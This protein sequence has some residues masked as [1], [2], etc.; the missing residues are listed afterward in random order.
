MSKN[1]VTFEL[2]GRVD[3]HDLENGIKAFRR[4]ISALTPRSA[5]V[6]WVVEDLRPGSMAATLRGEADDPS[7]VEKVIEDYERIG[8]ALSRREELTRY[9]K[10]IRSAANAIITL[11]DKAEYV[12]FETSVDDYMIYGN[13]LAAI[14]SARSVSV[15]AVTG[16]VQTL[17]N[18]G[19]LRF[20]LYDTVHD[21]AVACYLIPGQ[22]ALMREAWG[23]TA[24]VTGRV[25]RETSTGR[26][27]AIRK[28]MSVDI[29]EEAPHLSYRRA[30]GTVPWQQG[31]DKP[32]EIIRRLRDA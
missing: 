6:A 22:E 5:N 23:R 21:K 28:V 7:V 20:N 25:S 30:R 18:R 17:I 14:E 11:T 13:G 19:G 29:L 3:I 10:R 1:T 31:Y 27:I 4:L 16:R 15:G 26:P 9:K 8:S 24:T 2:G 32:E 12:R